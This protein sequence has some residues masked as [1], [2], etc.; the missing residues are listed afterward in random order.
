MVTESRNTNFSTNKASISDV[1]TEFIARAMQGEE[2]YHKIGVVESVDVEDATAVVNIANG[3]AITDV[4]LQQIKTSNGIFITPM[5]GSPVLVGWSDNTTAFIALYSDV[6]NV[7]YHDGTNGGLIKIEALTAKV[8]ALVGAVNAM[9]AEFKAHT[10]NVTGVSAPT[11][12]VLPTP[13]QP[14]AMQFDKSD[15]ENTK[16]KH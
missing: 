15:Y 6:Q 7:I 14:D 10:H 9:Y 12:P 13:A 2:L 5:V 8:N 1:L 16:V 4:R 11:G 3:D